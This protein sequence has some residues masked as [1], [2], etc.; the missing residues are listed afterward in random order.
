MILDLS[1]ATEK[2]LKWEGFPLKD[3]NK[4]RNCICTVVASLAL[5]HSW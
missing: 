3:Y 4:P 5:W 2:Y 1:N